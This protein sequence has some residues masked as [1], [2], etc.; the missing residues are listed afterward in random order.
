MSYVHG[1][2]LEEVLTWG[3][4]PPLWIPNPAHLHV[5]THPLGLYLLEARP[6][7]DHFQSQLLLT[8]LPFSYTPIRFWIIH[9][10]MYHKRILSSKAA[11][12]PPGPPVYWFIFHCFYMVL[13]EAFSF[14]RLGDWNENGVWGRFTSPCLLICFCREDVSRC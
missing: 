13:D 14:Y 10:D 7:D 12:E 1:L 4:H 2:Q 11:K 5:S 9:K 8:S 6:R 3:C